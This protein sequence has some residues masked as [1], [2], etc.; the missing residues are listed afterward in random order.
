MTTNNYFLN[1]EERLNKS[2]FEDWYPTVSSILK[3][4][5]LLDYIS[6]DVLTTMANDVRNGTKIQQDLE[7]AKVKDS[8]ARTFIL[9]STRK[10][11]RKSV[12]Q[13]LLTI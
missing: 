4:K 8:L 6:S 12:I 11:K 9:T 10:L 5:K 7:A 3:S 1:P 2:N 13:K